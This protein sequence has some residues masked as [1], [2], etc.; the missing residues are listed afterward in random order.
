[1]RV[2]GKDLTGIVR[3]RPPDERHS[4]S[5]L[6]CRWARL[7]GSEF[8]GGPGAPRYPLTPLATAHK[9]G[10]YRKNRNYTQGQPR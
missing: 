6:S 7:P 3:L 8:A 5:G 2:C 10:T 9:V 4:E 1:M